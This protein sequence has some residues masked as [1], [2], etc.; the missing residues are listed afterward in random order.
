M[1]TVNLVS[2]LMVAGML[3]AC[4]SNSFRDNTVNSSG[5]SS[6]G[7]G[8][9]TNVGNV[10]NLP[11][12]PS[13][14]DSIFGTP[15]TGYPAYGATTVTHSPFYPSAQMKVK[16]TP[17]A[18][19]NVPGQAFNFPYGC[20]S[21]NVTVN[22]YLIPTGTLRVAGVTQGANSQCANAPT[23]VVL[24]FSSHIVGGSYADVTISVPQYDNCRTMD[25]HAYG[26]SMSGVAPQHMVNYRV[27]VQPDGY[28][29]DP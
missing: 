29:L 11:A 20:V 19:S 10:Q 8:S 23:S 18:A 2:V 3:A 24:D 14:S 9:G 22:G 25:L 1:K 28:W 16:I 12:A 4:G 27:Q 15:A 13:F 17:L 21:M 26:C 7:S 6:G 5:L